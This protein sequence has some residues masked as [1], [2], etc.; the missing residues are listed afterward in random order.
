MSKDISFYALKFESEKRLTV[1]K[2]ET[3]VFFF[4]HLSP[5]TLKTNFHR[6]VIV[7]ICWDTPSENI[8]L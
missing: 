4:F 6:F 1:S 8:G 2:S 7:C 5:A 3:R